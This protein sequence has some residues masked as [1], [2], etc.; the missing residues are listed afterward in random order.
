VIISAAAAVGGFTA[1]ASVLGVALLAIIGIFIQMVPTIA[2]VGVGIA[3]FY[4]LWQRNVGGI[5]ELVFSAFTAIR[6]FLIQVWNEISA[7]YQRV[8]PDIQATIRSFTSSVQA[9]WKEHGAFIVAVIQQ[10]W[11]IIKTV[12][13]TTIRVVGD[14]ISLF[15]RVFRGDWA[16]AWDAALN[17]LSSVLVG[18]ARFGITFNA[19][20]A[21]LLVRV[22]TQ[23]YIWAQQLYTAAIV[24]AV[25]LMDGFVYYTQGP[26]L[27]RALAA[28]LAIAYALS[29]PSV[30]AAYAAAG[31]AAAK[32]R[33][34]AYERMAAGQ[35]ASQ[36][37]GDL[38]RA[39]GA[40]AAAAAGAQT[41]PPAPLFRPGFGQGAGTG[42]G[43]K[44]GRKAK[45]DHTA[46]ENAEAADQIAQTELATAERTYSEEVAAA[47]RA[48]QRRYVALEAYV[49]RAKTA[50]QSRLDAALA[51]INT[52]RAQVDDREKNEQKRAARRAALDER[53]KAAR[54]EFNK[55]IQG[56]DDKAADVQLDSLRSHRESL[57]NQ[58]AAI[59]QRRVDAY[60][61]AA[62]RR[63]ISAEAS[64]RKIADIE[65]AALDRRQTALE[66]DLALA[67]QDTAARQAI[68]DQLAELAEERAGFEEE[69]ARRITAA[70]DADLQRAKQAARDLKALQEDAE[71]DA[72]RVGALDIERMQRERAN[73]DEIA[74][75]RRDQAI[76]A[77]E[78]ER[79]QALRRLTEEKDEALERVKGLANELELKQQI[80][81]LYRERELL[82]TEEFN[83]RKKEI[84][85]K[86][87]HEKEDDDSIL[88]PIDEEIGKIGD[89]GDAAQVLGQSIANTFR[90]IRDAVGESI[91]AWVLY[92]KTQGA[93]LRKVLAE[94]LAALAKE[95]AM[96]GLKQTALALAAL[97]IGNF[98]AAARHGLSAA[99]WY[100]LAGGSAALGRK[101]AGDL[102]N[103]SGGASG[104]TNTGAGGAG[105]GTGS[106]TDERRIIEQGR[107]QLQQVII[108][109][110]ES[111]DSHIIG[112]VNRDIGL[113]GSTRDAIVKVVEG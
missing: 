59:D 99:A 55:N 71:A 33:T 96:Q 97:A 107:N 87:K 85:D 34:D 4:V 17:I 48:Y 23:I 52:E 18:W 41:P 16:G 111:N 88:G 15:L 26:G 112:V 76:I 94:Q 65:R 25:R 92:G 79:R 21:S 64:E 109:R 72:L 84:E 56:L 100:A 77:A 90:G 9:F 78:L 57:L 53:E 93:I 40:E 22:I 36:G 44:K 104:G 37:V 7:L 32:A 24:A 81:D 3:A 75:A 35:G 60:K 98:G 61:A 58:A 54:A 2:A 28:V 103:Q 102:F 49:A 80:N 1:L 68:N 101:V 13:I 45:E 106:G 82:A 63:S 86:Y 5:R 51:A 73:S 89:F 47:E 6:A 14:V 50:E 91:S 62:D 11:E 110:V 108:L 105:G 31:A 20:V 95:A 27:N 38:R 8:L 70:R 19:I 69:A 46:R 74:R 29:S 39:E 67:G 113:N 83:R 43:G 30:L 42:A 12:V 10:A 66:G